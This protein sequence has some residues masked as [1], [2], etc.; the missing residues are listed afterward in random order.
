MATTDTCLGSLA[1]SQKTRSV[2]WYQ[3]EDYRNVRSAPN[4]W[5][6]K[7]RSLRGSLLNVAIV[8]HQLKRLNELEDIVSEQDSSLGELR[9]KLGHERRENQLLKLKID[10]LLRH[11]ADDKDRLMSSHNMSVCL[12]VLPSVFR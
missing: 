1:S 11:H 12:S 3:A 10:D 8:V 9:E 2:N 7:R 4:Q 5:V 6:L